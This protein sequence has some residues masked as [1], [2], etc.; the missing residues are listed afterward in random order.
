[1][2]P[3]PADPDIRTEITG[4]LHMKVGDNSVYSLV[5]HAVVHSTNY[6]RGRRIECSSV[7]VLVLQVGVGR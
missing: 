1:V 7:P 3:L 5:L 2:H 4:V 6:Y